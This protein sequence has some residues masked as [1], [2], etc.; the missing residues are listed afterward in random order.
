MP[1]RVVNP[2]RGASPP[3]EAKRFKNRTTLD[4]GSDGTSGD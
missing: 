2:T 3:F 4:D 1:R